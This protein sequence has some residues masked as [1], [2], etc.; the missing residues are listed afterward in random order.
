MTNASVT[1]PMLKALTMAAKRERGNVC[2][3][4]GVHSNAET[5][6]LHA[7]RR[8]CLI[9]GMD[10]NGMGVPRINEAGRA[11]VAALAKSLPS[12]TGER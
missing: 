7:L 10:E 3:I 5:M 12:Q 2:P 9:D 6:L 1:T 8:R 4:V 11:A